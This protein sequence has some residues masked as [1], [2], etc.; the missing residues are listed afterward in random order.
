MISDLF[1]G[2]TCQD[3]RSE[4]ALGV[5]GRMI[6]A[7]LGMVGLE[8]LLLDMLKKMWKGCKGSLQSLIRNFTAASFWLCCSILFNVPQSVWSVF[9]TACEI[10]EWSIFLVTSTGLTTF[11]SPVNYALTGSLLFR[12]VFR[13]TR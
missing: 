2:Q 3:N 10:D 9:L 6:P 4:I 8:Y 11:E 7:N 13:R 5:D 12:S 1:S